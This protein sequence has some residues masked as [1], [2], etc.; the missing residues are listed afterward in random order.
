VVGVAPIELNESQS[1]LAQP[2]TTSL[3]LPDFGNP[4]A[5]YFVCYDG[6]VCTGLTAA[7]L[8]AGPARTP[9]DLEACPR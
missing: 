3:P 1:N 8:G 7:P 2:K 9:G 6:R 4:P 5:D